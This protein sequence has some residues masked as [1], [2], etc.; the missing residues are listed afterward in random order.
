MLNVLTSRAI[1]YA[2][3]ELTPGFEAAKI[4]TTWSSTGAIAA[5]VASDQPFDLVIAEAASIDRFI[6]E[7]SVL[8]GSRVDLVRSGIGLAV[9]EGAPKPDIGS[10]EAVKQALLAAKSV[11]YSQ[12]PSGVYLLTLFEKMG[13]AAEMRAKAIQSTPGTPV[14]HYV[15]Y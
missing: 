10:A 2:Y 6:A 15:Q 7:A 1:E 5:Q 14:A 9:K 13:V 11:G 4:I 8:S 3:E 12:G